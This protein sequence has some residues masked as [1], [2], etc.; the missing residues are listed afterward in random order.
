MH[1]SVGLSC[2]ENSAFEQL[3]ERFLK[4]AWAFA[5]LFGHISGLP[6]AYLEACR[7]CLGLQAHIFAGSFGFYGCSGPPGVPLSRIAQFLRVFRTSGGAFLPDYPVFMC[8]LGFRE[9]RFGRARV[10]PGV[11]GLPRACPGRCSGPSR[12]HLGRS[13]QFLRVFRAF[14]SPGP[15]RAQAC[16]GVSGR[17]RAAPG[18]SGRAPSGQNLDI[19][20][21]I[22]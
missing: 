3:S 7:P 15:G 20:I 11:P 2:C 4:A 13:T 8:V 14:G 18:V 12:V 17:A 19:D 10:A 22:P 16:P 9:L 6:G 5:E 1:S 21:C